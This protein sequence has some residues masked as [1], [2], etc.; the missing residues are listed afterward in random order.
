MTRMERIICTI[1][2]AGKNFLSE[3]EP[4]DQE[5]ILHYIKLSERDS[6]VRELITEKV[7]SGKLS[8]QEIWRYFN[9]LLEM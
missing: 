9:P 1:S 7:Q 8:I 4:R 2:F 5:E 6:V 3:F